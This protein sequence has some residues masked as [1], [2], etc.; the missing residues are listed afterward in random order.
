MSVTQA[1]V[2][3][4][5]VAVKYRRNVSSLLIDMSTNTW[6][7]YRSRCVSQH[8]EPTY[9]SSVGRDIGRYVGRHVDQHILIDT[10]GESQSICRP[11][12]WSSNGRYVDQQSTDMSTDISVEGCINYT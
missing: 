2:T 3:S 9:R 7:M 11:T 12:Y 6:P 1:T 4:M 8:I 5:Q 10:L